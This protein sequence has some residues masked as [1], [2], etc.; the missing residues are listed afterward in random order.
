MKRI[1]QFFISLFKGKVKEAVCQ[2][3]WR[4]FGQGDDEPINPDMPWVFCD[5]CGI[6]GLLSDE[7]LNRT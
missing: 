1:K 3:K 4:Q 7:F 6:P 5:K 2:H